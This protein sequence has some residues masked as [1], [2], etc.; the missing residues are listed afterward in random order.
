LRWGEGKNMDVETVD[1]LKVIV[2]EM[3]CLN[4]R[5]NELGGDSK[6]CKKTTD[7]LMR[8]FNKLLEIRNLKT[9][10]NTEITK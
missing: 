10:F 8:V 6:E 5:I 1:I 9:R 4:F 7:N 2:K 3:A